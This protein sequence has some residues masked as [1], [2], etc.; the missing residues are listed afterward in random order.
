MVE[1]PILSMELFPGKQSIKLLICLLKHFLSHRH[2][3]R[4]HHIPKRP[5]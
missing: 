5:S 3:S 2:K 1:A 4:Q